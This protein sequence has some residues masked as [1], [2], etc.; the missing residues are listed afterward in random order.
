MNVKILDVR[1]LLDM[2]Y[3]LSRSRRSNQNV[4]IESLLSVL[5]SHY[6]SLYAGG[7]VC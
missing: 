2:R 7:S 1:I 6:D 3:Q 5:R 4:G